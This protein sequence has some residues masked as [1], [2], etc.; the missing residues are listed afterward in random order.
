MDPELW[1]GRGLELNGGK[2]GKRIGPPVVPEING[3][4]YVNER[5]PYETAV[6]WH[7]RSIL[8]YRSIP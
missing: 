7:R 2:C 5:K 1:R 6:G 8:R 3:T 4:L